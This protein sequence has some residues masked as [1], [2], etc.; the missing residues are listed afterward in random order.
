MQRNFSQCKKRKQ[1]MNSNAGLSGVEIC[2]LP[3]VRCGLC[4][5]GWLLMA[6]QPQALIGSF[7]LFYIST[8]AFWTLKFSAVRASCSAV[9]SH[10]PTWNGLPSRRMFPNRRLLVVSVTWRYWPVRRCLILCEERPLPP[11]LD[12]IAERSLGRQDTFLSF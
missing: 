1:S 11:V 6:R 9:P 8:S 5:S 3:A 4:A 2:G 7:L 10:A 12:R